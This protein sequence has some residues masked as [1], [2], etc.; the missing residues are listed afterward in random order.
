MKKM[1]RSQPD[2]SIAPMQK[3]L[4]ARGIEKQ[5]Q[6]DGRKRATKRWAESKRPSGRHT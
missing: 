2:G 3:H 4:D 6:L 1:G 5:L